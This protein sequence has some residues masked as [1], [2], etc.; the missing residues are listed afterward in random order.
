M[1]C[2][3]LGWFILALMLRR[4]ITPNA[5]TWIVFMRATRGYLKR[6]EIARAM[7]RKGYMRKLT[8]VKAVCEL[9]IDSDVNHSIQSL[10]GLLD[11]LDRRYGPAWLTANS[12]G[13]ILHG[14]GSRG[15]FSRCW[16]FLQ[17]MESRWIRP[18]A[19][20]INV[21]LHHCNLKGSMNVAG[22]VDILRNLPLSYAFT[23]NE[24]TY[25]ILFDMAWTTKNYNIARVVWRYACL[26]NA[27]TRRMRIL[28]QGSLY[29]QEKDY[30]AVKP[31]HIPVLLAGPFILGSQNI[32]HH[33]VAKLRTRSRYLR[34]TTPA[35]KGPLDSL[36]PAFSGKWYFEEPTPT[37]ALTHLRPQYDN[38]DKLQLDYKM[39]EVWAPSRSLGDILHE[40]LALDTEWKQEHPR[41]EKEQLSEML[42]RGIVIPIEKRGNPEWRLEWR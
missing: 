10:G 29:A 38:L 12:A 18:D 30:E 11:T 25:R 3:R 21:I 23:P 16:D 5:A 7:K 31:H 40:A 1:H 9:L 4:D 39:H 6:V 22:A 2:F 32:D 24:D 8:T 42:E 14:F 27:S 37:T 19:F 20:C 13:R 28:L 41:Q 35:R 26:D 33:P 15:H 17:I 34:E 36:D